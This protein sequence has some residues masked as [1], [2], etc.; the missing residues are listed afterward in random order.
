VLEK[1]KTL[2]PNKKN[3]NRKR[4]LEPRTQKTHTQTRR[5]S[6]V[7]VLP[8][9]TRDSIQKAERILGVAYGPDQI[10]YG[11]L[12]HLRRQLVGRHAGG[13]LS[14]QRALV[15]QPPLL[16]ERARRRRPGGLAH[17]GRVGGVA[18]PDG[19]DEGGGG[20]APP[21]QVLLPLHG[22]HLERK[23]GAEDARGQRKERDADEGA[24]ARQQ[25]AA[26]CLWVHVPVPD[27]AQCDLLGANDSCLI[28]V[29][30]NRSPNKRGQ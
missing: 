29:K 18:A 28:W 3:S 10:R 16:V 4:L 27:C 30:C 8:L 19:L 25:L 5:V 21:I 22:L 1:K 9:D 24:A 23:A 15:R 12:A 6:R 20:R 26:R 2:E 17:R 11:I 14:P 13:V 7:G